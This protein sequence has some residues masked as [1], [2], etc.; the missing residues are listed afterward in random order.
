MA[1]NI[2]TDE[3]NAKYAKE[4]ETDLEDFFELFRSEIMDFIKINPDVTI[5]DI[6]NY[7]TGLLDGTQTI[8]R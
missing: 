8:D 1:F 5:Q 6:E 4:F 2:T 3:Q 7:L